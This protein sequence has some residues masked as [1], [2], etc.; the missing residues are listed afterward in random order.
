MSGRE[1]KPPPPLPTVPVF[2]RLHPQ[3]TPL[4]SYT[5]DCTPTHN[6]NPIIIFDTIDT[7]IVG[8]ISN[9]NKAADKEKVESLSTWCRINDLH[10]NIKETKEMIIDFRKT[11]QNKRKHCNSLSINSKEADC[12]HDLNSLGYKEYLSW[13]ANT[14]HLI[15]KPNSDSFSRGPLNAT[16]SPVKLLP[17]YN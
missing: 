15:K 16:N 9:N 1:T 13:S 3:S 5:Y 4:L 8:L 12:D 17:L 11:K 6:S 7:T 14:L 2:P 10:L